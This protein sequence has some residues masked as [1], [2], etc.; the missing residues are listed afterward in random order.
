MIQINVTDI[1]GKEVFWYDDM[2]GWNIVIGLRGVGEFK[3]PKWH[4][5]IA[6]DSFRLQHGRHWTEEEA[7]KWAIGYARRES[8]YIEFEEIP[9]KVLLLSQ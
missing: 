4:M 6:E 8:E 5:V 1:K 7:L 9:N 3:I 2:V